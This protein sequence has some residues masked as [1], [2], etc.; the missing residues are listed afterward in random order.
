MS[1]EQVAIQLPIVG[2]VLWFVL[3]MDKRNASYAA[4]RDSEWREF[5]KL[6]SEAFV[7]AL[8]Q[9]TNSLDELHT[10]HQQHDQTMRTAITQMETAARMRQ[11]L[12]HR[13]TPKKRQ[14]NS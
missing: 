14:P 12:D 11:K 2:A 13:K 8:E 4:K 7:R 10:S 3:E 9:V 6:Q 5:L 1:W